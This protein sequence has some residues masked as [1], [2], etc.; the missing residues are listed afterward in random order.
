MSVPLCTANRVLPPSPVPPSPGFHHV[1]SELVTIGHCSR[2]LSK[3]TGGK[4]SRSHGKDENTAFVAKPAQNT[5]A[6]P[7]HPCRPCHEHPKSQDS[8]NRPPMHCR[9]QIIVSKTPYRTGNMPKCGASLV[10]TA[11]PS[12][13]FFRRRRQME[14]TG[15]VVYRNPKNKLCRP[16]K[17]ENGNRRAVA[18]F[19]MRFS[20]LRIMLSHGTW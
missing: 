12:P 10:A 13:V 2:S 17:M 3:E 7:T 4:G 19:L 20:D 16:G 9:L 1:A 15:G 6:N 11:M 5:D 8:P 18:Q 14:K